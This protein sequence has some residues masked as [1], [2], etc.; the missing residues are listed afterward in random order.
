M[1]WAEPWGPTLHELLRADQALGILVITGAL[2]WG[3]C[4]H[5]IVRMVIDHLR[6]R[7]LKGQLARFLSG[8]EDRFEILGNSLLRQMSGERVQR[9]TGLFARY[10]HWIALEGG[11]ASLP[12]MLGLAA[13][14]LALGLVGVLAQI[15]S[16]MVVALLGA[17]YPFIRLRARVKRIRNEMERALPELLSLMSAE[18][19]AG[20][21]AERAMERAGDFGGPLSVLIQMAVQD[22]RTSR[23][24]MFGRSHAPGVWREVV[25]RYH[26]P[27]LRAF[28]VQ[29]EIAARKGA[30]GPELMESLSKALIL[31]YRDQALR[32]AEKFESRLAVPTVLFFF[33]PLMALVLT[34]MLLPLLRSLT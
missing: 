31:T 22:S 24:P 10:R 6:H 4:V 9:W 19:A 17:A 18:M 15:P 27:S 3:L 5:A 8:S 34:P 12:R 33:L 7:S 11:V 29:V 23:R 1:S 20:V 2:L 25:E 30:A 21:P 16:L 26:L 32:A 14:A 13:A 28:A